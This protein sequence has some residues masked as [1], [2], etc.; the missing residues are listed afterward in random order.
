MRRVWPLNFH[1]FKAFDDG[2]IIQ[3]TIM[4]LDL[5]TD[6]YQ[7]HGYDKILV[8][9]SGGKDSLACVL[10][11]LELGVPREKIE[12]HHHLVDGR[13]PW[14]DAKGV[15]HEF[16]HF[17][18]WPITEGYS[19]SVAEFLGIPIYYS[20]KTGGFK[21]EMLREDSLT[22]PICWEEPS[23]EI[24]IVGGKR[25]KLATRMMFPQVSP[26]LS[27]RW[28]SAYLK[29]D[30][31]ARLIANSQRFWGKRILVVTG[32][33]GEESKARGCYQVHEP[34]RADNRDGLDKRRR[35]VDHFRPI[36]DWMEDAVWAIIER[37]G[38][39]AH[40]CY[41]LGWARCSCRFCI[42]GNA[43]QFASGL[44]IDPNG[45]RALALH[46]RIF[47]KTIKRGESIT[48]CA[49]RGMAYE[50]AMDSDLAAIAMGTVYNLEIKMGSDWFLPAG[51]Y[52]E[53]A[54]P[55]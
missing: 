14:V 4:Q 10:H 31:L 54:G 25:G 11:L 42:F 36:R 40:P 55:S 1:N 33:R 32:E 27:V 15:L 53:S 13:G 24:T 12:L 5:F 18:D 39:R 41:Y 22:L 16:E 46:E 7:L 21:G 8:A 51:A 47:G 3:A 29:I 28:C 35:H 6:P 38:I 2:K 23:G 43:N 44:H 45:F 20:W 30:V 52:G 49:A 50:A 9:F 34:D 37:W 19:N 26:D 17:M 48:D